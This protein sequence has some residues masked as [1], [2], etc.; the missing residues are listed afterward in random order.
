MTT[1]DYY[2]AI[3]LGSALIFGTVLMQMFFKWQSDVSSCRR[4]RTVLPI[5]QL[6]TSCSNQ[7]MFANTRRQ[8][9]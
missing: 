4:F 1:Q 9:Y 3:I 5:R 6:R 8:Y 2:M 7:S